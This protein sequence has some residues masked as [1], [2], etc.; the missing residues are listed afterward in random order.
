MP[1]GRAAPTVRAADARVAQAEASVK[2]AIA[3]RIVASKPEGAPPDLDVSA[4]AE[5][6]AE[7]T[8]EAFDALTRSQTRRLSEGEV[9]LCVACVERCDAVYSAAGNLEDPCSL[10][11]RRGLVVVAHSMWL[12]ATRGEMS[13]SKADRQLFVYSCM[14]FSSVWANIEFHQGEDGNEVGQAAWMDDAEAD[15]QERTGDARATLAGSFAEGLG[16]LNSQQPPVNAAAMVPVLDALHQLVQSYVQSRPHHNGVVTT[17]TRSLPSPRAGALLESG[18]IASAIA[19]ASSHP[20]AISVHCRTL[21]FLDHVAGDRPH[22]LLLADA[23]IK[24]PPCSSPPTS[25][26]DALVRLGA[27]KAVVHAVRTFVKASDG[28]GNDDSDG[29][30]D[31]DKYYQTELLSS[32]LSLLNKLTQSDLGRQAARESDVVGA[33]DVL[34]SAH[35]HDAELQRELTVLRAFVGSSDLEE[36]LGQLAPAMFSEAMAEEAQPLEQRGP[37]VAQPYGEDGGDV[38]WYWY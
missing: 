37:T 34:L 26:C 32:T 33:V 16:R 13:T 19:A 31:E 30:D 27:L 25:L 15:V 14:A 3:S 1:R 8:F 35:A 4:I 17:M 22:E 10:P 23:P 38:A 6:S 2:A 5:F 18:V 7:A 20:T 29:E 36:M 12:A 21:A 11:I 28:E 24:E 9:K